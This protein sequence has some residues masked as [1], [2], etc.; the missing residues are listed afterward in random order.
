MR[1]F[2]LYKTNFVNTDLSKKSAYGENTAG[3]SN[4]GKWADA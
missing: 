4:A 2:R 3:Q 1:L